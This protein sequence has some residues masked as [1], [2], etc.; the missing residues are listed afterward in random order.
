MPTANQRQSQPLPLQSIGVIHT[1]FLQ[2]FGIPRQPGLVAAEGRLEFLAPFND[3]VAVAGL[4][5]ASHVWLLWQF[6]ACPEATGTDWQKTV[7]PPRLGGNERLGVFATRS[8]FRPNR[9]GMSVCELLAIE[10]DGSLLLKGV[11]MLDGTPIIDI[12]PYVP[13][14]DSIPAAKMAWAAEAPSLLVVEWSEPATAI[15]L[16][17]KTK[18]LIEAVLAQDPRPAYQQD[19]R[20][21][22]LELAGYNVRF[23]VRDGVAKVT[24][25]QRVDA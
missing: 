10:A 7:R 21:Y 18:A 16:E 15:Q 14:A 5:K 6:H 11:D 20:D 24:S 19:K 4:T 2:K 1:P 8:G 3:P 17:P 12:K 23:V 9:I 13:Y 25:L 22:G